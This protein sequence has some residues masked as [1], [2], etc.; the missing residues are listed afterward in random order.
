MPRARLSILLV[1]VLA[2]PANCLAGLFSWKWSAD[3]DMAVEYNSN[4]FNLGRTAKERV[5]DEDPVALATGRILDMESVDDQRLSGR[6]ELEGRTRNNQGGQFSIA[7]RASYHRY[8]ENGQKSHPEFRL[9]LRQTFAEREVIE[10]TASYEIDAFKKNYL[11]DTVG[12]D[13]IDPAERIYRRGIHDDVAFD[14]SYGNRIWRRMDLH[15]GGFPWVSQISGELKLGYERRRFEDF[16][17]RNLNR[18]SAGLTLDAELGRRAEIEFRYGFSNVVAPGDPE[19]LILDEPTVGVDLNNDLDIVD[20]SIRTVQPVDRSRYEHSFAVEMQ[21]KL[22]RRI[23]ASAG[24]RFRIFDYR[25]QALLDPAHSDRKD[26]EHVARAGFTWKFR[27]RWE[28]SIEG[29]F[30]RRK[31][32]KSEAL[33]DD[34]EADKQQTIARISIGRRF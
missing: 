11:Y 16:S 10:L 12:M 20:L 9:K 6:F 17:N 22:S 23:R 34:E 19:V 18:W 1:L 27:K 29:R 28:A 5:A 31:V 15:H 25:S 30:D 2:A 14:V 13:V 3:A 8:V 32:N 26:E 21:L 33:L 24:Y 4:V 7:T